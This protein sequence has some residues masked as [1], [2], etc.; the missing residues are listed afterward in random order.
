MFVFHP[1]TQILRAQGTCKPV[2]DTGVDALSPMV[3][4]KAALTKLGFAVQEL[5]K[6]PHRT[7]GFTQV[8]GFTQTSP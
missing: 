6:E 5:E 3:G 1:V 4:T 7:Y 2:Q 8:Y